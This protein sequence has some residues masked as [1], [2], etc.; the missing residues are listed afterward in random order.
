VKSHRTYALLL[1]LGYSLLLLAAISIRNTKVNGY[2]DSIYSNIPQYVWV[3]LTASYALSAYILISS[4]RSERNKSLAFGLGL[5]L[6]VLVSAFELSIP[7]MK[8]NTMY[9]T[10]DNWYHLQF[11]QDILSSGHVDLNEN[12]YP[13]L[14][15]LAVTISQECSID[16]QTIYKVTMPLL[17]SLNVLFMYLFASILLK[18]RLSAVIAA[19]FIAINSSMIGTYAAPWALS[20]PFM[21]LVFVLVFRELN[22][23]ESSVMLI[24]ALLGLA[25]THALTGLIV[26]IGLATFWLVQGLLKFQLRKDTIKKPRFS[27]SLAILAFL[28]IMAWTFLATTVYVNDFKIFF[29]AI[30]LASKEPLYVLKPH[31]TLSDL[32]L[33]T[34][35]WSSKLILVIAAVPAFLIV[36]RGTLL[37]KDAKD[38]TLLV[39]G[40]LLVI[41]LVSFLV[42]EHTATAALVNSSRFLQYAFFL[43]PV[44]AGF[45]LYKI[46]DQKTRRPVI[47]AFSILTL[48]T[49]SFVTGLFVVYQSPYVGTVNLQTSD[50]QI[51]TT[52]WL[53]KNANSSFQVWADN[54]YASMAAG[55]FGYK[56]R[57][58][59]VRDLTREMLLLYLGYVNKTS[60]TSAGSSYLNQLSLSPKPVYVITDV[61][62]TF[63]ITTQFQLSQSKLEEQN[64]VPT[65]DLIYDNNECQVYYVDAAASLISSNP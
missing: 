14:H 51:G 47:S 44:Y 23:L 32:Q 10:E 46:I 12:Y 21:F 55:L 28:I 19:S 42:A 60:L 38:S 41:C 59:F 35:F 27:L 64:N 43:L 54:H 57:E 36:L 31:V 13:Q 34:R 65:A 29:D 37:K 22:R 15:I 52:K 24:I 26:A 16:L 17:F 4:A 56:E 6:L 45:S 9:G 25:I 53:V 11:S 30:F 8:Y 2:E 63:Y 50:H 39:L 20:I 48:L 7:I 5:L 40:G 33:F 62:M 58:N 18:N 1:G 3:F 61:F 49:L